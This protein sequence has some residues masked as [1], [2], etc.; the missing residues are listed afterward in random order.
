M[1]SLSELNKAIESESLKRIKQ[2][3]PDINFDSELLEK[4]E[5]AEY[6]RHACATLAN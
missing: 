4:P 3:Y 2:Y 5:L 6:I 1:A